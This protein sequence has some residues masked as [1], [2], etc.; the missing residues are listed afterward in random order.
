MAA[1]STSAATQRW[2]VGLLALAMIAGVAW[3]LKSETAAPGPVRAEQAA[4]PRPAE[5]R[6]A[7]K[8]RPT[9]ATSD[10]RTALQ[11]TDRA[12]LRGIVLDSAD[13]PI[14]GATVTLMRSTDRFPSHW[15]GTNPAL[16]TEDQAVA[17]HGAPRGQGREAPQVT[18]MDYTIVGDEA[19]ANA[20]EVT[21]LADANGRFAFELTPA[22]LEHM[23]LYFARAKDFLWSSVEAFEGTPFLTIH[24]ER[25]A[26]VHVPVTLPTGLQLDP[27]STITLRHDGRFVEGA[28]LSEYANS[29]EQ[30]FANLVPGPYQV[31]IEVGCMRRSMHVESFDL[32]GDQ[33][34][35]LEQIALGEGLTLFRLEVVNE[36][37]FPIANEAL[38]LDNAL[39][40]LSI[41]G[42]PTTTDEGFVEFVTPNDLGALRLYANTHGSATLSPSLG[43]PAKHAA[44][45]RRQR[46]VVYL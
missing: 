4:P 39:T 34:R 33:T 16:D 32:A 37:G 9:T 43:T 24:L 25:P 14:P 29:A 21:A 35:E 31:E 27:H 23:D 26:R 12:T 10:G 17:A 36:Y 7:A 41:C 30:V 40:G 44:T 2:L 5:Q 22:E 1:P 3:L 15:F 11:A 13:Q 19:F 42:L 38:R 6:A 45:A 20:V 28:P 8:P 46:V 18:D